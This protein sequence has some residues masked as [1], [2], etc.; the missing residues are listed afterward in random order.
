MYK[1]KNFCLVLALQVQILQYANFL[2]LNSISNW[3]VMTIYSSRI[4]ILGYEY[5]LKPSHGSF[6]VES[7]TGLKSIFTSEYI[8]SFVLFC[9]PNVLQ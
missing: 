9:T 1:K 7:G 4:H 6:R 8:Y 5:V 3:Q 2:G